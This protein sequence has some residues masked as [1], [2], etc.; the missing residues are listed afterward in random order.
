MHQVLFVR[1]AKTGTDQT[2]DTIPVM[3]TVL[4]SGIEFGNSVA[5]R[6]Q[7][8]VPAADELRQL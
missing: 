3:S 1:V 5:G 2:V 8:F 7:T 4:R 6:R